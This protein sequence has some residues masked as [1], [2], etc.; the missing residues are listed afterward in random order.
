M[1]CLFPSLWCGWAVWDMPNWCQLRSRRLTK[2]P[3]EVSWTNPRIIFYSY[4][5]FL[6]IPKHGGGGGGGGFSQNA[7]PRLRINFLFPSPSFA[8]FRGCVIIYNEKLVFLAQQPPPPPI[9]HPCV[10]FAKRTLHFINIRHKYV[11]NSM[12]HPLS[13]LSNV[14]SLHFPFRSICFPKDHQKK[15]SIIVILFSFVHSVVSCLCPTFPSPHLLE[16]HVN[17][18]IR[19]FIFFSCKQVL[20]GPSSQTSIV[21]TYGCKLT[22][23][24][25]RTHVLFKSN[26]F[27][28]GL[29]T[30]LFVYPSLLPGI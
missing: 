19:F 3:I 25:C 4:Y 24:Q 9:P 20:K 2:D 17:K 13:I 15:N 22:Y 1:K 11:Y 10:S 5:C 16:L 23:K 12:F 30:H 18:H 26:A 6:L 7:F 27:Y 8:F 21:L 14:F 28:Y 29:T